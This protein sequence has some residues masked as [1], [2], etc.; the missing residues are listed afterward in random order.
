MAVMAPVMWFTNSSPLGPPDIAT[1]WRLVAQGIL[2]GIFLWLINVAVE[3]LPIGD[4]TAIFF[5]GPVFT[6]ILSTCL[7][8]S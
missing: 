4:S 6:M 5:S 3:R 7:L 1:R 8:R 2:G